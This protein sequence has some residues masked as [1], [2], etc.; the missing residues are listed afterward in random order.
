MTHQPKRPGCAGQA[1]RRRYND[2]RQPG[3]ALGRM[4]LPPNAALRR[5][6]GA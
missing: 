2:R 1:Q 6:D 4:R 5:L 3:H